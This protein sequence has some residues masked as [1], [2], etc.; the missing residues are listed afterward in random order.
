MIIGTTSNYAVLK[1]MGLADNFSYK[2][3]VPYLTDNSQV[4]VVLKVFV[5][6]LVYSIVTVIHHEVKYAYSSHNA[7]ILIL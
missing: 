4:L 5:V 1:Q 3:H 6:L 2:T 7:Y